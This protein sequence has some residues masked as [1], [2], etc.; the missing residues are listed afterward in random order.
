LA[1][2]FAGLSLVGV[3]Q[4]H[5]QSSQG[6]AAIERTIPR[7]LPQS[8]L[9]PVI[10]APSR[11]APARSAD[12]GRFTLG[13]V[14]IERATVF[15]KAELSKDFEPY[16]ATEVDQ[17]RLTEI[18]ARI[19]AR[20]R[21]AGYLLSYAI[22]P[23]Q[24]VRAGIVRIVILEG[25]VTTVEVVGAGSAKSAIEATASAIVKDTPLRVAT[26]ERAI[27]LVRDLPGFT[28]TDVRLARS[29]R[30][31]TRH[32][33][34]IVVARDRVRALAYSD[35]RGTEHAGRLRFYSSASLSSLAMAG[36]ELRFDLFAIPGSHLRYVYGQ[37]LAATPIGHDGLRFTASASAGDLYQRASGRIDGESTNLTAQLSY[38]VLRSRALTIVAK[39][40]VNDWRGVAELAGVRN[41]R[42]R[43]RVARIGFDLSNE[44][45]TRLNGDFT[46]SR[47]LGF[48]AMT[49][50]GDPLA[51]RPDASGRFTKAA[52]SFQAARPVSAKA[53]VKFAIAGQYSDRPLL[54]AEE[55]A[56]GGS[57]FGRAF[58]FNE[59]TGDHGLAAG[60]EGA[61]RP[62]DP[63]RGPQG[64]ELFGYVD[65][66]RV[67]Q[68]RSPA[69]SPNR[70]LMSAGL[71]SRFSIAG[72]A[73]SAEAG[74]PLHFQGGSK[75]LRGFFT[76]YRAF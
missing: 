34:K 46:L 23:P 7:Q 53:T 42:D 54:S 48:D 10:A 16:L 40:A 32:S 19:T 15:S 31:P 28:V 30:D 72:I 47:G 69:S 4:A 73:F 33:L 70:S 64:V 62:G 8:Q 43:L 63:K 51:S 21:D 74:V 68:S 12:V 76:A 50:V 49:R 65:G 11:I 45:T 75:S 71:G 36:D 1:A 9:A 25:R 66:G 35:N 14:N 58:D 13:A 61:Y 24:S 27:G 57:R 17:S 39:L 52:F 60:I 55:F 3:T 26:L 5:A 56:L 41:Q 20:Y 59:L 38:P 67:F 29:D 6:P 18:A 37:A 2:A 44:S 22:V